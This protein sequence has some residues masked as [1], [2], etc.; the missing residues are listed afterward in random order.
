MSA[1][2]QHARRS[3]ES[4][5]A[6][7]EFSTLLIGRERELSAL[8]SALVRAR[9]GTGS[10]A[11]VSG[12]AGIGKTSLVRSMLDCLDPDTA[13][14]LTGA[15]FDFSATPPYGPWYE[16]MSTYTPP[17]G[18]PELPEFMV[19]S[20]ALSDLRGQEDLFQQILEFFISLSTQKPVILVLEDLHWSDDSSLDLL[21]FVARRLRDHRILLIA[22]FRDDEI[23]R[24]HAL[25]ELLPHLVRE[26]QTVRINPSSLSTDEVRQLI[27]LLYPLPESD[28]ETTVSYLDHRAEGNPLF[29]LESLRQLE[30]Q[31]SLRQVSGSWKLE[32]LDEPTVPDLIQQI[33]EGRL[34]RVNEATVA[35]VQTASVIGH[36]VPIAMLNQL[37][38][39]EEIAIALDEAADTWLL[40]L[41]QTS[42]RVSF[43]HALVR[44]AVYEN[45]PYGTRRSI[46][47]RIA[48][49]NLEQNQPHPDN[50]AWHLR[51]AGDPR[52]A[53]WLIRAGEHADQQCASYDAFSRYTDA[54]EALDD[55]AESEST[56]AGLLLK[57]AR[58]LRFFDPEL[59]NEYLR[60]AYDTASACGEHAIA[61]TA[62]F[63]HG[64]NLVNLAEVQRG[65]SYMQHALD[66]MFE[67]PDEVIDVQ[68]W[69]HNVQWRKDPLDAMNGSLA[70]M[71][72]TTG[73]FQE[74]ATTAERRIDFD[75]RLL[76]GSIGSTES[77]RDHSFCLDGFYGLGIALGALG[78]PEDS[79]LA[80]SLADKI[81]AALDYRPIRVI[82]ASHELLSYH[83]P[84]DTEN[85]AERTRLAG[86]IE[87]HLQFSEGLVG[88][89]NALWG[90]EHYLVHTGRWG[91]LRTL[92]ETN[93][94]SNLFDYWFTGLSARA[95]LAWCEG[96][97]E[98]AR[99]IIAEL[100]PNGPQTPPE[101]QTYFVPA[102]PH[103][104]AA[105]I[106]I[107]EGDID[108]ARDWMVAHDWWL[109]W[110]EA[111]LG[112]ADGLLLW[113]RIH[114]AEGDLDSAQELAERAR[115]QAQDPR[116]PMALIAIHRF[117]GDLATMN[118]DLD[119][120]DDRL[121]ASMELAESCQ[122]PFERA[123]TLLSLAELEIARGNNELALKVLNESV[124]ICS[125]LRAQ[126][127]LH[128]ARQLEETLRKPR[129]TDS[130]GL[131]EREREVL[132]L[133]VKGLTDRQIAAQLYI[134]HRTV[135][136]HV[137]NILRKLDVESRT[138][139][140]AEAVRR[141]LV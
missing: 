138:A 77:I 68:R 78:M 105:G 29:I 97:I 69:T 12:E 37:L 58:S 113:A 130:Y 140:A 123:L 90:Y 62:L 19:D 5:G 54:L 111:I 109:D 31:G 79:K 120:A 14:V 83:F 107:D 89:H 60:S 10:L 43:R 57:M 121:Q 34:A 82:V 41:H 13:I 88:H 23:S 96:S 8:H 25:F 63:N 100:L 40:A 20:S 75:W 28:M 46:H 39:D 118:S 24:E 127:T 36:E 6:S 44:E 116:Q 3:L 7:P 11:L 48:E 45:T 87:D 135:M 76:A 50:V 108:L 93:E 72:A 42:Q 47:R 22:T 102:E 55:V 33:V 106:A 4:S 85:L 51:R 141:Q 122:L 32:A 30:L 110:S 2:D 103:R 27:P 84:Y 17:A 124:Q 26:A 99:E 67:I 126:P 16:L 70:L 80:F 73:R 119:T 49:V 15:C 98:R 81:L 86:L 66:M 95:R 59:A 117:L 128:R 133:L 131:S 35:L 94:P 38:D 132:A 92:I 112:R 52:A 137:T 1:M 91:Q 74:A 125:E 56:R 134:S 9:S 101:E 129:S 104:I 71:L 139:A 114:L 65:L 53:E 136:R 61:A 64:N 115:Q 21:R 18:F